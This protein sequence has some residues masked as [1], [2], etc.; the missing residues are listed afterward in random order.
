MIYE[1]EFCIYIIC[2]FVKLYFDWNR[3][4][5]YR[6]NRITKKSYVVIVFVKISV[7]MYTHRLS[8]HHKFPQNV[9][10]RPVSP[11]KFSVTIIL[12]GCHSAKISPS[13]IV[14]GRSKSPFR[15]MFLWWPWILSK[16][17]SHSSLSVKISPNL[18]KK[19]VKIS[20]FA[21]SSAMAI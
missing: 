13:V 8:A 20:L 11:S 17:P 16:L 7:K 18:H 2:K 3:H 19:S 14:T 9:Y 15:P 4:N 10:W 12:I 5:F 21:C 6:K 1:F